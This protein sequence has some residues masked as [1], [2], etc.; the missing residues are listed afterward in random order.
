MQFVRE[1]PPDQLAQ[2]PTEILQKII[3]SLDA[4][5]LLRCRESHPRLRSC[6]DGL[7]EYQA[8]RKKFVELKQEYHNR[9]P[10]ARKRQWNLKTS[11]LLYEHVQAGTDLDFRFFAKVLLEYPE[12]Q[13]CC[14]VFRGPHQG[15][16]K[17][18][19]R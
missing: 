7:P 3:L 12:M 14:T 18:G 15:T 4:L 13:Q 16:S 17:H 9:G 8:Y 19:L 1:M 6:V 2:L 5:T 11:A 10:R